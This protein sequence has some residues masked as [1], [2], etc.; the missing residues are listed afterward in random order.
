MMMIVYTTTFDCEA[1]RSVLL[2]P[3]VES[4]CHVK[5]PGYHVEPLFYQKKLQT[6]L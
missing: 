5:W 4:Q 6:T 1:K 3:L 2:Y